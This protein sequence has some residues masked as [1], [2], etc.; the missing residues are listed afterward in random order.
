MVL[1]QF[2]GRSPRGPERD[3]RVGIVGA[4]FGGVGMAIQL[5]KLGMENFTIF[6]KADEI[7]GVWRDNTYPD[8]GCDVPSHLYSYSFERRTD[9]TRRFPKQ[10]E[11]LAYLRDC[12]HRHDLTGHIRLVTEIASAE[13]K[14]AEAKWTLTTSAGDVHDFDVVIWGLGQLNR[15]KWPEIDGLDSFEGTIFHSARWN[16]DHDLSGERIAVIGNGAS[17]VQFVPPV[18][19]QASMLYQFQHAPNWFLPKPDAPFT[20]NEVRRFRL[21]PGWD[22]LYRSRLYV[23]FDWKWVALRRGSKVSELARKISS[24]HI[25]AHVDDPALRAKLLPDY[26]VGCKRI[27]ISD[28]YLQTLCRDDVEV[29]DDP[30]V[31]IEADAIVTAEGI[32]REVDTIIVATGFATTDFLAPVEIIGVDGRRL[33]DVWAEGARAYQGIAVPGFPNSFILYGP[34][35]NLNHNSIIFMLEAQFRW[36]L[37]AIRILRTGGRAIDVRPAA[38]RRYDDRIQRD[39]RQTAFAADCHSWYKTGSGRITNNWPGP[40]VRY[41]FDTRRFRRNDLI[42]D[43]T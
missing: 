3:L 14:S 24:A 8:A 10:P 4:G 28:N 29:V 37:R 34:N 41:W 38:A 22:R 21:I 36:I 33:A 15:P 32:R 20:A 12:A 1:D 9:W 27:L 17:A 31:R 19:E 11:I 13:W 2:G 43:R 7:G 6:E 30:I 16:H 5:R 23:S 42:V 25:E 35:T 18:A 40:T 39:L 26:P